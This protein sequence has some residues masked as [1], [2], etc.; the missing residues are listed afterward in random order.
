M[1]A[2]GIVQD[3]FAVEAVEG[4]EAKRRVL[5]AT[6]TATFTGTFTASAKSLLFLSF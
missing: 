3:T 2:A 6:C 5:E 1:L 4:K